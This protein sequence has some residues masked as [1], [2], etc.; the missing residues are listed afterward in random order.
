MQAERLAADFMEL[1]TR[2]NF[3]YFLAVGAITAGGGAA[4]PVIPQKV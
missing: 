1:S 4:L 2:H 3:V